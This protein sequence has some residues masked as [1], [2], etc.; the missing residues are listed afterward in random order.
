[1]S[2]VAPIS[3]MLLTGLTFV[4][5]QAEKEQ[6]FKLTA[7]AELVLLSVSVKDAKGGF[8]SDLKKENFQVFENGKRQTITQFGKE[9]TPITVGLVVDD[10]RSM[11]P[12]RAE[13]INAALAFV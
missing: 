12:K 3:C 10:S 13:V 4:R 6:E 9:D 2:R 5:G 8:A 11:K 7:N 1:M